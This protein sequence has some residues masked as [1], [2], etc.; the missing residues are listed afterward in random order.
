M[1]YD[2]GV[3]INNVTSIPSTLEAVKYKEQTIIVTMKIV[4]PTV[5]LRKLATNILLFY[6]GQFASNISYLLRD[7]LF[8]L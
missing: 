3:N 5:T 2:R 6:L 8:N 1:N 4:Q 7:L